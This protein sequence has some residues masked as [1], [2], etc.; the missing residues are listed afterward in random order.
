MHTVDGFAHR[1]VKPDNYVVT[2]L[3]TLALIDFAAAA[4][5][6]EYCLGFVGT[7][8]YSPPEVYG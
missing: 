3:R 8:K 5:V 1:D 2:E 6:N 4:S 7:H